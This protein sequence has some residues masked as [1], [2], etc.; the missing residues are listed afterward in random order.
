MTTTGRFLP[1]CE[2]FELKSLKVDQLRRLAPLVQLSLIHLLNT[3]FAPNT[4]IAPTI[5]VHQTIDDARGKVRSKRVPVKNACEAL[6][7]L[8]TGKQSPVIYSRKESVAFHASAQRLPSLQVSE[9]TSVT[10]FRSSKSRVRTEH[11]QL[12]IIVTGSHLLEQHA[13][14]LRTQL[15]AG[16]EIDDTVDILLAKLTAGARCYG[17]R[18]L[19]TESFE[20]LQPDA[21]M[22][23][24]DRFELL[25]ACQVALVMNIPILHIHGGEYNGGFR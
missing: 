21:T 9:P 13:G 4:P 11:F 16:I 10:Y 6:S 15:K 14:A 20:R 12:Q 22:V 18:Y 17:A 5:K 23:F 1:V 2:V 7:S 24:G 19:T 25:A 8:V 3:R